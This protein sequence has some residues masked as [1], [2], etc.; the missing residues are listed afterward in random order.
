MD[1]LF[2]SG[3]KVCAIEGN[4]I[5]GTV[6]I[7]FNKKRYR[8][9]YTFDIGSGASIEGFTCLDTSMY[10]MSGVFLLGE[11]NVPV[12]QKIIH[13]IENN[14]TRNTSKCHAIIS[15]DENSC[16]DVDYLDSLGQQIWQGQF[17]NQ[18]YA[19]YPTLKY[20][21][22]PYDCW[23]VVMYHSTARTFPNDVTAFKKWQSDLSRKHAIDIRTLS[24]YSKYATG[25]IRESDKTI[26]LII[27]EAVKKGEIAP[28]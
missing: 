10:S 9:T 15:L 20:G 11:Y 28:I 8:A 5:Y 1:E 16:E 22:Y 7:S 24:S 14:F 12:A 19:I 17:N 27:R 23:F 21:R 2:I 26:S 18:G 6:E 25:A 13:F 3:L 4:Q